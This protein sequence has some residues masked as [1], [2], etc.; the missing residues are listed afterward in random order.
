MLTLG[1]N[2]LRNIPVLDLIAISQSEGLTEILQAA[3]A[4][5]A[6]QPPD[7]PSLGA[8]GSQRRLDEALLTAADH[9]S[10]AAAR[11]VEEVRQLA[12]RRKGMADRR[13]KAQRTQSSL[14]V[15]SVTQPMVAHLRSWLN[16]RRIPEDLYSDDLAGMTFDL[17][18]GPLVVQR[19]VVFDECRVLIFGASDRVNPT[20]DETIS[21]HC[22]DLVVRSLQC[23]RRRFSLPT[24]AL[25]C[26]EALHKF[27]EFLSSFEAELAEVMKDAPL[28][29]RYKEVVRR[30]LLERCETPIDELRFP[31]S[32]E[33]IEVVVSGADV[34]A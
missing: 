4:L 30:L 13:V 17:P 28:G 19:N 2:S 8:I 12:S 11:I 15:A 27:E 23:G 18:R 25:E 3:S 20:L 6:N 9:S 32:N 31:I 22:A 16:A 29:P 10:Q 7:A 14:D 5:Y 24:G 21:V 33:T 34:G 1:A 26:A